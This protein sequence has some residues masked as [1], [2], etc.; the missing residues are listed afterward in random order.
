MGVRRGGS[1]FPSTQWSLV[2]RAG[3]G[4]AASASALESL[5][6][7]YWPPIFAHLRMRGHP[8]HE[9]EDLTQEFF[10]R[11]LA[12]NSFAQVSAERGRFRTFLLASLR[13]FTI[14]EWK[15]ENAA[16]RGGGVVKVDL[17][18]M[19]PAVRD[20]C[21]PRAG[22]DMS[23]MFCKRWALTLLAKVREQMR[24]EYEAAGQAERHDMLKG[25]LLDGDVADSY[26][27]TAELLG[28]S[29]AAVKSAVYKIRQRF[30]QLLRTEIA[31]TVGSEDDIE[32]ELRELIA[33][34]GR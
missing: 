17:D 32:D 21:E 2:L 4:S 29:E 31:K 24:R 27:E 34:L 3:C 26:A 20:A 8:L 14:N 16:K 18:A 10:T 19:D 11:L 5:C 9:A 12:G 13:N 25:Y 22:E 30:G 1:A 7:A 15:R 23:R 6:R 33:A 28:I